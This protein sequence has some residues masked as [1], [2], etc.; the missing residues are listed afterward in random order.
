MEPCAV[1]DSLDTTRA[2]QV[3]SI[4]YGSNPTVEI[5]ALLPVYQCGVCNSAFMNWEAESVR[6]RAIERYK[7]LLWQLYDPKNDEKTFEI[8][9]GLPHR[10]TLTTYTV[11]IKINGLFIKHYSCTSFEYAKKLITKLEKS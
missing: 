1:C 10:K 2:M 4:P 7:Q 9:E 3:E 5:F 8:Y 6:T 11:S